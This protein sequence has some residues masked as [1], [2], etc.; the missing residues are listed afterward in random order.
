MSK[1]AIKNAKDLPS[2]C[3]RRAPFRASGVVSL[4]PAPEAGWGFEIGAEHGRT[5]EKPGFDC[6]KDC[7][8]KRWEDNRENGQQK[9]I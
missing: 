3:S 7:E 8:F 9:S 4:L 2:F 1:A 5:T 6:K